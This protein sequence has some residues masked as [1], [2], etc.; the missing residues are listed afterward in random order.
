MKRDEDQNEDANKNSRDV[1]GMDGKNSK[2]SKN[3]K[4]DK[5]GKDGKEYQFEFLAQL[6]D[7]TRHLTCHA[8]VDHLL[9]GRGWST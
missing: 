1:C 5:D 7:A 8:L 2:N 3:G 6:L 9:R 4:D